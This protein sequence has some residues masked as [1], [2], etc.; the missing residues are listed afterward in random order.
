LIYIRLSTFP[1]M[2]LVSINE[3]YLFIDL[4]NFF[5]Y[6]TKNILFI[7]INIFLCKKTLVV[8]FF[9]LKKNT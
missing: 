4:Y 6:L 9:F 8:R 7:Y 3:F 5:I 1:D 2:Y